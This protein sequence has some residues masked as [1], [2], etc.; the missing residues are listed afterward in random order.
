MTLDRINSIPSIH[1]SFRSPA[2]PGWED[3]IRISGPALPENLP[4]PVEHAF[5][6][7]TFV[8]THGQTGQAMGVQYPAQTWRGAWISTQL[9]EQVRAYTSQ[10]PTLLAPLVVE[11]ASADGS[12]R[13][14]PIRDPL[15][16]MNL[17][18]EL[19]ERCAE[20]T[21]FW[22]ELGLR[23]VFRRL[24]PLIKEEN[25]IEWSL[26]FD[27]LSKVRGGGGS[28]RIDP[29]PS[30][31]QASDDMASQGALLRRAVERTGRLTSGSLRSVN[32]AM[33]R[34]DSTIRNLQS[35]ARATIERVTEPL[36]TASQA[37]GLLG[38]ARNALFELQQSVLGQVTEARLFGR[39]VE[40][41]ADMT[42]TEHL[43]AG[44]RAEIIAGQARLME[45]DALAHEAALAR[46][47]QPDLVALHTVS[48]DDTLQSIALRYY[49]DPN[50]WPQVAHFSGIERREQFRV[51]LVLPI[52]RLDRGATL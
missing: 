15:V 46:Q 7:T 29:S 18:A 13:V 44:Y 31:L 38:T 42:W 35:T 26:Q 48:Q 41:I 51:G 37:I 20:V 4:W 1:I 9:R 28:V 39:D 27:P 32:T 52:P 34:V 30:V 40:R 24:D 10:G 16:A 6:K 21:V 17:F 8:G 5:T 19:V 50:L 33:S 14:I 3:S 43:G 2:R 25:W 12:T 45:A 49:G 23:G 22:S 11:R 36:D 47:T